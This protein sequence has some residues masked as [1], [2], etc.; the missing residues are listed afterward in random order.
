MR[1]AL[2][3]P[4]DVVRP[5]RTAGV[6]RAGPRRPVRQRSPPGRPRS[7]LLDESR[8]AWTVH[9]VAQD[10]RTPM[11]L[12]DAERDLHHVHAQRDRAAGAPRRCPVAAGRSGGPGRTRRRPRAARCRRRPSPR[13]AQVLETSLRL[14]SHRRG[15]PGRRRR[16]GLGRRDGVASGGAARHRDRSA[17]CRRSRLQRAARGLTAQSS[18]SGRGPASGSAMVAQENALDGA[19]P[20]GHRPS[21]GPRPGRPAPA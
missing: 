10:V 8:G 5:A 13:A 20:A 12:V 21:R 9:Q 14:L 3:R 2:P 18:P 17:A 1:L 16:S 15:G 11:S 19:A 6:Q 7:G 4:G